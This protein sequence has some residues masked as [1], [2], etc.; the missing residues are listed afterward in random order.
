MEQNYQV[1][2][3]EFVD[4]TSEGI[5]Q[6][7]G[8]EDNIFNDETKPYSSGKRSWG[9]LSYAT[10]WVGLIVSIPV[11]MLASGLLAN[12]M[13]WWQ[14]V[15]TI[16]L[17]HTIVMV[18][19]VVLGHFG[20]KYGTN[21]VLLSKFTFGP[22]GNIFPTLVRGVLGCFWFGIQ[23]WI[24]GVALNSII[25]SLV[26]AYN[27]IAHHGIL[28]FLIFLS[29]NII[30]GIK[31]SNFMSFISK[32]VSVLLILLS[33]IVIIWGTKA[34]G[35]IS[36]VFSSPIA[37]GDGQNF[38]KTFLPALTAMIAFDSTL[39]INMSDFTRHA[40]SQK[41]QIVGQLIGAPITTLF[42]VLVG[43]FGTVGSASVFGQAIWDPSVL[44]S[45]FDNPAI[46]IVFSVF[47]CLAVL[48]TNVAGNLIPPAM[49]MNTLW[50]KVFKY[51]TAVFTVG[52][53][54]FLLMPWKILANPSSYYGFINTVATLLGPMT[55]I[56][57]VVYMKKIKT[58]LS[59]VDLYRK[60]GGRYFYTSG[61]NVE[62]VVILLVTTLFVLSGKFFSQVSFLYDSS[63]IIGACLAS[64]LYVFFDKNHTGGLYDY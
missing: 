8:Y 41:A 54:S 39:A 45:K 60:D 26:P 20:T 61:W 48:S 11:Y 24:G 7:Q 12:G 52:V 38:W 34:A 15:F 21:Y 37:Q 9:T 33:L 43:L 22:R 29:F 28:S 47:I 4:I 32:N 23:A 17:G 63:Y 50:P 53:I 3:G 2:A 40:R 59:I 46:V 10:L 5:E 49:V 14:A 16:V 44:V 18:P 25:S 27:A 58:D 19:A 30:I 55:G 35:G 13:N 1:D 57:M 42:I 31:G 56:Y 51:K 36:N 64:I 6:I 62:G